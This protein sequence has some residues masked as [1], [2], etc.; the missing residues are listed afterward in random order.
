V[1]CLISGG[2]SALMACPLEG[3][4]LDDKRAVTS[5][6]ISCGADIDEINA[7]R[8][9]LSGTKGGHLAKHFAPAQV[10]SLILSECDRLRPHLPGPVNFCGGV[11][12]VAEISTGG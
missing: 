7:V 2:G 9:H 10:I 11:R 5:L 4:S 3:I 12:G 1:L 8:K 6:L